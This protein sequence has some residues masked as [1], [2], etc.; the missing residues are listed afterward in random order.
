[1]AKN[2]NLGM[3]LDLLLTSGEARET[4]ARQMENINQVREIMNM[5]LQQDEEGKY[6][7][8]YYLYRK[9]ID[10]LPDTSLD[11]RGDGSQILS[12]ALNNAA[13]IL[14]EHDEVEKSCLY[15]ERS[16][17]VQPDNLVA[18]SNL[19]QLKSSIKSNKGG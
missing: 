8:A 1:M 4:S 16:L 15:L 14:Y 19:E 3:G 13:I 18:Q 6:L 17:T 11:A 7:E 9:V 5:A 10:L 2:K 12:Q